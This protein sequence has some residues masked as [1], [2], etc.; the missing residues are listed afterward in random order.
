MKQ[1]VLKVDVERRLVY[2][3]AA[4]TRW[5]GAPY[6]DSEGDW[7]DADSLQDAVVKFMK[8]D[9]TA[10]VLHARDSSGRPVRVGRVVEALVVD[11]EKLRAMFG[12]VELPDSPRGLF[13][14]VQVENDEVWRQIKNGLLQGFSISGTGVR[15]E[16]D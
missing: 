5:N 3:W 4:L 2:G 9:R 10:G 13:V 1:P 12:D 16:V 11:D 15:E 14:G 7:I 6:F 8:G